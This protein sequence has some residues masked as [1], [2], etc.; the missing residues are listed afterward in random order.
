MN[1]RI[2]FLAAVLLGLFGGMGCGGSD[3]PP[4][5]EPQVTVPQAPTQVAAVAEDSQVTVTWAAPANDGGSAILEYAVYVFSGETE[6]RVVTLPASATRA[7]ITDLTNG[8][9]YAFSVIAVND[10]GRGAASTRTALVTP[11]VTPGAVSNLVAVPGNQEVVLTWD[12]ADGK[13]MALTG[14]VITAQAE[15]AGIEAEPVTVTVT[16]TQAT[17]ISLSNGRAYTFTVVADNGHAKGAGTSVSATP[18]T[19]P[20]APTLTANSYSTRVFLRWTAEDTGGRPITGYLVTVYLNDEVLRTAETTESTLNVTGLLYSTTYHF[21]VVAQNE[22]GRGT[23]SERIASMLARRPS[24]PRNAT[25]D[26]SD[27]NITFAWTPPEFDY[28]HP[29]VEYRIA[30]MLGG[31]YTEWYTTK[32][33]YVLPEIPREGNPMRFSLVA[34]NAYGFGDPVE[35][36]CYFDSLR[37]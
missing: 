32:L 7:H 8:T 5:Q 13:G 31:Y 30:T 1:G 17:L 25:C 6:V 16:E 9:A 18:F 2:R 24:V 10:R 26:T 15:D 14:Y 3:D 34:Q 36:Y 33:R 35:L 12:A 27:E 20:G 4:P 28:G 11:H 23:V 29:V 19:T 37:P 22:A 21:T